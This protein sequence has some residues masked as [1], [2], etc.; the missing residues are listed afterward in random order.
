MMFKFPPDRKIAWRHVWF[1]AFL[2]ALLFTGGKELIGIYLGHASI[3]SSFGA[4]G[5]VVV[6]T[7]WVY[8]TSLI[9]FFG[10]EITK[11]HAQRSGERSPPVEF[12]H[13]EAR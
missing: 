6:L 4:A 1:G 9:V 10:A 2:T 7:V 5:S 8:Y 11:V 12:A 13:R 3:G